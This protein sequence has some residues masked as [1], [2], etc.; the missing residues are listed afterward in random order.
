[1]GETLLRG[2]RRRQVEKS[3]VCEMG[4]TPHAATPVKF[5]AGPDISERCSQP[6]CGQ[7]YDDYLCPSLPMHSSP[8]QYLPAL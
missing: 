8:L 4:R 1:M 3:R 7:M 5:G 2:A 6:L